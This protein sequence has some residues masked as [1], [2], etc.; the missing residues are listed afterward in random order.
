[1]LTYHKHLKFYIKGEK[2]YV[3]TLRLEKRV[4]ILRRLFKTATSADKYG[5]AAIE[6]YKSLSDVALALEIERRAELQERAWQLEELHLRQE[7][8]RR[9]KEARKWYRRLIRWVKERFQQ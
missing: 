7:Q 6:R 4:R 3:A 8:M 1:M 2:R 5:Q 9:E